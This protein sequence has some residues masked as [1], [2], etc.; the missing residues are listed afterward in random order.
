MD[1]RLREGVLHFAAF[2]ALSTGMAT[3]QNSAVGLPDAPTPALLSDSR[4]AWQSADVAQSPPARSRPDLSTGLTARQKYKLAWRRIIS[5]QLPLRAA[6]VSGWELGTDTGPDLPTNGWVPFT[7]R[8]GYNAASISTTIFFNT[9]VVPAMVHQDPRYF[10]LGRGPIK[11]RILWVVRSEFVGF[12]DDGH[13][14]PNYANLLG[15]ALSSIAIDGFTPRDSASFGD[16]VERYGIKIGVSTGLN[17]A[18]EFH[19]LDYA[20]LMLRHS[21]IHR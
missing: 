14:M 11:S 1:A 20:K 13:T 10:P 9:A 12:R 18:R 7:E 16:T 15:F 19:T 5:P 6:F 3:A 17:V 2:L 8:F 21:K 4:D